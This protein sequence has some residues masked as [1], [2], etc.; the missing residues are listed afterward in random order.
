MDLLF[1][2]YASP[3][4]L[5]DQM[6]LTGQFSTFVTEIFDYDT[7]DRLWNIFLHKVDGQTS[8]NDWK[9]SIGLGQSN[10]TEMTKN[11]I[12]ATI[13]DSFDILNGFEPTS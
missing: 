13:N 5:V 7:D 12:E 1:K 6:L 4:L 3:F 10:N 8:F 9:A 11:E 2:R